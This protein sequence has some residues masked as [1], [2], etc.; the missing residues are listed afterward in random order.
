MNLYDPKKNVFTG[1]QHLNIFLSMAD[2]TSH[3]T[4]NTIELFMERNAFY[5][6]ASQLRNIYARLQAHK[7]DPSALP[8]VRVKLAYIQGKTDR[9][10]KGMLLLLNCLDEM[11]QRIVPEEKNDES[12]SQIKSLLTFFEAV[13]AY[14]KYYENKKPARI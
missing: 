13:L 12:L 10:D 8:L 7:G 1:D 9:R 3:E 14:H 2:G 5:M 11:I 6:T 4:I